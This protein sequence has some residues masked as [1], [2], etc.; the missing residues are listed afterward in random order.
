MNSTV[1][2]TSKAAAPTTPA[3]KIITPKD[4]AAFFRKMK[5]SAD[6]SVGVL[7]LALRVAEEIAAKKKVRMTYGDVV[8]AA[9]RIKMVELGR[10]GGSPHAEKISSGGQPAGEYDVFVPRRMPGTAQELADVLEETITTA[11]MDAKNSRK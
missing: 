6:R 9:N 4:T 2:N 3:A 5:G 7:M 1:A 11:L 8:A 10:W